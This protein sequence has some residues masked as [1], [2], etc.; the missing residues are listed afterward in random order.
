M[1]KQAFNKTFQSPY[2]QYVKHIGKTF[3]VLSITP[4]DK[5]NKEAGILYKIKL[6]DGEVIEAWPE[7]V[8]TEEIEGWQ[9]KNN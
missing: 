4:P 8:L 2:D 6:S 7:E 3:E 9:G 5:D 1:K